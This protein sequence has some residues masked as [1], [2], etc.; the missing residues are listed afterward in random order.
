MPS[1]T[2]LT[3]SGVSSAVLDLM[4]QSDVIDL[5]VDSYIWSRL[6]GYDLHARHGRGLLGGW[7]Y[8]QLDLPR[9]AEGG[10]TGA[11]W[12]I[13]TNP[14]R[15][16]AGRARALRA[17]LQRIQQLLEARGD[18]RVVTNVAEYRAARARNEHAAFLALQ[19]GNALDADP[20][21][22]A[23][24]VILRVT[25]VH[26][27]NSAIGS[28]S[29]PFRLGRDRGLTGHG[30]QLVERMN[31]ERVFVD[32]AH[33]SPRGFADVL[34]V[35]DR[36]QPLIVTHTGVSAVYPS[37]RNIDDAQLRAVAN[38]G[39]VVGVVFHGQYLA[40]HYLSG[41]ALSAVVAHLAHI[42][43]V[44]GEDVAAIG[45]DWDGAIIPP[46]ELRSCATLPKLVQALLQHGLSERA[47]QK[48]LGE[49]FL[50]AL[51]LLR[52]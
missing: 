45:S 27:T 44:A 22:L 15:S 11:M 48:L 26:M 36:S 38:T 37:W 25:L 31:A 12:S 13:T 51:A 16:A 19:G 8:S 6:F 24:G 47:V 49:N 33:I 52:P 3:S 20:T 23:G 10:L 7:F 42:V 34:A 2:S 1:A 28:T 46:R 35:H 30:R 5:H 41:G 40:G 43:R 21:P 50:R 17:N 18:A 39:G 4:R 9:A 32:L 14:W 29:S